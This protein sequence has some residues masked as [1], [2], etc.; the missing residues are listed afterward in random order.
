MLKWARVKGSGKSEKERG[1]GRK[2]AKGKGISSV[3]TKKDEGRKKEDGGTNTQKNDKKLQKAQKSREK[4]ESGR[5]KK[6]GERGGNEI[7]NKDRRSR[8]WCQWC[9]SP[10]PYCHIRKRS[11]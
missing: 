3:R 9:I 4:G 11:E 8:D 5:K 2:E 1:G 10:C 6:V 7:G